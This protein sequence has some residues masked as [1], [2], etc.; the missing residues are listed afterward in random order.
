MATQP[1][2]YLSQAQSE[3]TFWENQKPGVIGEVAS[4]LLKPAGIAA[5]K[6]IPSKVQSAVTTGVE[7]FLRAAGHGAN[8]TFDPG[9]ILNTRTERLGKARAMGRKLEVSDSLATTYWRRN[10]AYATGEGAAIG[11]TGLAGLVADVPLLMTIAMRQIQEIGTSYGYHPNAPLEAD[12]AL[13][14]LQT[15]SAVKPATKLEFLVFLKQTEQVLI[16][17][18]WKKMHADLAAK[19][20][21]ITASLAAVRQF[22]K[23]LGIQLTKRKALQMV[24]IVGA[25][26]GASFNGVFVND[27]GRAAYMSYRRRFI[28]EN[29][30]PARQN[31][32][33]AKRRRPRVP[34][35]KT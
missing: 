34:A 8:Q 17:V 12:Y 19:T 4:F 6:L 28:A 11:A 35:A 29:A 23:T 33:P 20:I 27:V 26:V 18:A 7:G 9:H 1:S 22:A 15:G 13:Q 14:I 21:G 16:K 2:A 24:P 25:L 5:T 31:K 10:V 30:K 32:S 3:I